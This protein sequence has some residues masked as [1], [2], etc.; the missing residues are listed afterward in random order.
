MHVPAFRAIACIGH[1]MPRDPTEQ[2]AQSEPVGQ[3]KM[4]KPRHMHVQA[5][6]ACT[7]S[8]R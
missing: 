2:P 4:L 3:L 6:A 5:A 7:R 1:G 8:T